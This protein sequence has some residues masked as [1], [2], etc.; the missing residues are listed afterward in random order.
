MMV[1]ACRLS[2]ATTMMVPI[3]PGPRKGRQ[4]KKHA[5]NTAMTARMKLF[6]ERLP[7]I[8]HAS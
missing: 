3:S 6:P 5:R 2:A 4:S 1:L 7:Q 8:S